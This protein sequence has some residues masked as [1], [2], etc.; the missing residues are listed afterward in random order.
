[1]FHIYAP[2]FATLTLVE[3]VGGAYMWDLTFYLANM[4]HLPV[5][6]LDVDIG[7]LLQTDRS[8][9]NTDLPSFLSSS[10]NSMVR[11]TDRGWHSID[12]SVF[13]ALC[14]FVLS[15]SCSIDTAHNMLAINGKFLN[16][17]AVLWTPPQRPWT[18]QCRR[19]DEELPED[20]IAILIAC[21]YM[22]GGPM[23]EI[24]MQELRLK[25]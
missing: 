15:M 4:P 21:P 20:H 3:S 16:S 23:H 24:K 2:H 19:F 25:M 12:G 22:V 14:M 7:T 9:F 10:W 5:P 18:W 11:L 8:R 1:M 6:R 17:S 13:Q